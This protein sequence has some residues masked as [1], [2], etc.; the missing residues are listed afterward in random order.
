M[1]EGGAQKP[2]EILLIGKYALLRESLGRLLAREPDFKLAAECASA[3]HGL[4]VLKQQL[5]D[6]VLLEFDSAQEVVD[7]LLGARREGFKGRLLLLAGEL[8]GE[9]EAHLIRAGVCGVFHKGDSSDSLL[10]A[11]RDVAAGNLWFRQEQLQRALTQGALSPLSHQDLTVRERRVLSLV[12]DG[13]KDRE[14]A[15]QL[16]LSE[17]SAKGTLQQL[18]SRFGVR[19]RSRLVRIAL[20]RQ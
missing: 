2:T 14:I 6:V 12:C 18:F 10:H 8:D 19:S 7:F 4:E 11:I 3:A 5:V 20:Q 13:L 17:S 15:A 1:P 16:G 9:N